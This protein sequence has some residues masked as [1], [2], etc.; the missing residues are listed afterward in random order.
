LSDA[1]VFHSVTNNE[2]TFMPL[3]FESAIKYATCEQNLFEF[4]ALAF[5]QQRNRT[6]VSYLL[7]DTVDYY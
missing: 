5:D 4:L 1:A 6:H 2:T 3:S 7:A